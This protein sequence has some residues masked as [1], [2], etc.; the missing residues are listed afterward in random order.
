M[1]YMEICVNIPVA[2]LDAG[3]AICQMVVP[4]GIQIE[5][6]SDLETAGW[7]LPMDLIDEALLNK[8]RD[9][10][11]IHIYIEEGQNPN[12]AVSFIKER[13]EAGGIPYTLSTG[14]VDEEDYATAWKQY[15]H[16]LRVGKR[17]MV[18]PQWE[19]GSFRPAPDDIVITLDPGMAFGTGTHETTRLCMEL[20]EEYVLPGS[21][22]LD[23]GCGSGILAV[24]AML[25]GAG[26][27]LGCDIDP[28]A[29]QVAG[30]NAALNEINGHIGFIVSDLA[31]G[32]EGKF[33][34]ICANI[35]AD[36]VIRL[37]E[38]VGQYLTPGGVLITSGIIDTR[39]KDVRLALE[40]QG[41]SIIS[42]KS[43]GGWVAFACT[44]A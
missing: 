29:V 12:E 8:D 33:N 3:A 28:V 20:L 4:Y 5:D 37:A 16:P 31:S 11:A 43:E 19:K 44:L 35:V 13:M 42:E 36:V 41:F 32:I 24:T 22:M 18:V 30:E 39:A 21:A 6:Y 27:A 26:S 40:R 10:A 38:T 9:A 34:I 15:Y 2:H 17:L 25:L 23:V 14:A 1:K 7:E